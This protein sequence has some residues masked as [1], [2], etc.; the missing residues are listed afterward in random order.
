VSRTS[1]LEII[2]NLRDRLD[3]FERSNRPSRGTLVST[4][5]A[6]DR[7]MPGGGW[8]PGTLIE[9]L[10]DGAGCGS[11]TLALAVTAEIVRQ[12]G[13]LV[14]ID[15]KREFYPPAIVAGG[16]SLERTVVVQPQKT[17]D[18]LWALE[19]SLRSRAATVVLGWLGPAGDRILRRL[20][21][22]AETG[23]TFG[24]L[25]RP[26]I[27]RREPSHAEIRLWVETLSATRQMSHWRLRA[28]VLHRRGGAAGEAVELELSHEASL[29]RLASPLA[30][31]TPAS[32]A[33][34]A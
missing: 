14:V 11:A 28:T 22:A 25:L 23:E 20:Q 24:F 19:Q 9:W 10:S 17:D 30:R 29:M 31:S 34:G 13:I 6:L 32:G 21:L 26:A 8:C 12:S 27:C 3:Q 33:A 16:I 1:R 5:S 18:V 7:L 2:Q 4:D 15:P